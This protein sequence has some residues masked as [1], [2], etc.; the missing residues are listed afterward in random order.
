MNT[1]NSNEAAF[2]DIGHTSVSEDLK[3]CIKHDENGNQNVIE[4]INNYI[5]LLSRAIN[6]LTILKD[7]VSVA[8]SKNINLFSDGDD[9][10]INGSQ[11]LIDRFV[12]F[13]IASYPEE[14]NDNEDCSEESCDEYSEYETET[15]SDSGTDSESDESGASF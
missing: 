6:V 11:E 1:C 7:S 9:L 13:G 4:T 15:G 3:S 14:W 10:G 2:L 12:G 5:E 8:E